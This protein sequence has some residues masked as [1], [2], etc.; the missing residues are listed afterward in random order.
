MKKSIIWT[1][2]K[3]KLGDLKTWDKNPRKST[4]EQ[5]ERILQSIDEFG[6][7]DVFLV[8]PDNDVYNGH[9]R[10]SALLVK[11]GKKHVVDARRASRKLS[12]Q[13]RKKL[14]AFLHAGATGGWDW[15]ALEDWDATELQEWG[16]DK[17]LL[18]SW[19]TDFSSL[20]MIIRKSDEDGED[21]IYIPEQYAIIIM[22]EDEEKQ[23]ELLERFN[24][25]GLKCKA[26]LS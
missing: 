4:K 21:P 18:K 25:E 16:M 19:K 23:V 3:V 11:Y 1:N 14:T 12:E 13:E 2:C 8:G 22:C 9:Q 10:L 15:K 7:A 26:L 5:A 24:T 17:D 6:Q 20:Q